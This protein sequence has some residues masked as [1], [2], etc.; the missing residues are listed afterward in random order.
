[1]E[2]EPQGT[3]G[4]GEQTQKPARDAPLREEDV[5]E[6]DALDDGDLSES[7]ALPGDE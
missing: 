4:E 2:A 5:A 3:P 6:G 1:M 7:E